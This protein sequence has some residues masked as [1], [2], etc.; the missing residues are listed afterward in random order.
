M[1]RVQTVVIGVVLLLLLG[2]ITMTMPP[3]RAQTSGDAQVQV[4]VAI[5][6]LG[7]IVSEVGGDIVDVEVMLPEGV[8]PH[9]FTATPQIVEKANSADLLVLT[10][11]FP[12]EQ[13]IVSQTGTPYVSIEDYEERGAA[14]SVFP[15]RSDSQELNPHGYW[16]LPDNAIAI[17]NATLAALSDMDPADADYYRLNF[18]NFVRSVAH[19]TSFIGEMSDE[20][21]LSELRAV[22]IFPA[23]AYIAE[24]FGV[25][26][27]AVLQEGE[28]VFISGPR[29]LD[30]QQGLQN[31]SIDLILGSD[32]GD[33]QTAGQFA[34]QLSSD[35]GAPVVW[36]RAVFT[37]TADYVTL[38]SYNLG[39]LINALTSQETNGLSERTITIALGALSVVLAV[40]AVIEGV[41][42][43]R[44]AQEE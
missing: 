37:G 29:L 31:G 2:M 35:T 34:E 25:T 42:I 13:D 32:V 16:L 17:A 12:W 23:E 3:V 36:W 22:V 39:V 9:S 1:R 33:L 21:H 38:M 30:I 27:E 18:D 14:L 8:E 10:G 44:R 28:N 19:L 26:V 43:V 20:H 41:I 6:P 15:G 40:V 7:S 24:A 11:H 4:A 5:T